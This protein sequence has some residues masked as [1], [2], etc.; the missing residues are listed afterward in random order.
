MSLVDLCVRLRAEGLRLGFDAVGI[1]PA[2]AP[3]G[4]AHYLDWVA[5]GRAA[6]MGYM[7]RDPG[8]R[9]HPESI[10]PGARS[11]ITASIV[12]GGKGASG[13]PGLR[14]GKIARYARGG[15]YHLVV[16]QKLKALLAWLRGERPE[17]RGRAVVDTAP[18]LERDYARAAGLGWIGKNT[19]LIHKRLGSFT[20]LGSLLVDIELAYDVP[21]RSNHCGVCTRCLDACPT[22]AFAGPYELDARRCISYWTIEHR[23]PIPDDVAGKLEGWA[24]GCDICQEVCPWNRKAPAGRSAAFDARAE[25][26][27]PDLIAWLERAAEEWRRLLAGSALERARREGLVRNAALVLGANRV[28]EAAGPLARL[29]EDEAEE[30]GVRSAA[31]WALGQIANAEARLALERQAGEPAEPL[32][33]TVARALAHANRPS[34][35]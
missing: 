27:D 29:L 6:G 21:F 25:W 9:A 16:R 11:V 10:L 3:E 22:Q 5:R 17:V 35:K 20:F 23:G 4:Y 33:S 32:H 31:A 8:L 14:C 12:Y 26:T 28:E 2:V 18:L 1:A 13:A 15:D 7:E 34:H 30:L 24:F 19:M